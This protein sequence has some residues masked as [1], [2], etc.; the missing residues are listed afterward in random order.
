MEDLPAALLTALGLLLVLEG[1]VLALFP[2]LLERM[3]LALAEVPPDVRRLGGLAAM[4][5]GVLL[6]WAV[7]S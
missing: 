2:R 1:L 3:L 5:L 4:V 7:Q 6:V